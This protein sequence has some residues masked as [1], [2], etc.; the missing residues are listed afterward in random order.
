MSQLF[1]KWFSLIPDNFLGWTDLS[2]S[3]SNKKVAK[4]KIWG[5]VIGRTREQA[6]QMNSR[7]PFLTK[8][9]ISFN[10]KYMWEL[11]LKK[12]TWGT[13]RCGSVWGYRVGASKGMRCASRMQGYV[14]SLFFLFLVLFLP[15]F[16]FSS[17]GS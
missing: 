5:G 6:G 7:I 12:P 9:I 2:Y 8:I 17:L 11:S 14:F 10:A 1:L 13:R 15:S 16:L 3:L 4:G